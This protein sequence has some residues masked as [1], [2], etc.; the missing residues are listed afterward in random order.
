MGY[1]AMCFSS[2]STLCPR[3]LILKSWLFN[4]AVMLSSLV[5]I[6]V[7]RELMLVPVLLLRV[8]NFVAM[9]L[10]R[11]DNLVPKSVFNSLINS[12]NTSTPIVGCGICCVPLISKESVVGSVVLKL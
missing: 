2:V 12:L 1:V 11:L 6:S 7:L 8:L 9:V 4:L 10:S 3:L 5:L